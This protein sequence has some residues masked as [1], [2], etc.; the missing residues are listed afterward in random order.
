[1]TNK[2]QLIKCIASNSD[3][4]SHIAIKVKKET[5]VILTLPLFKTDILSCTFCIN[6]Y[7]SKYYLIIYHEH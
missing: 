7:F 6:F 5:A 4:P 3:V 1:M 2:H